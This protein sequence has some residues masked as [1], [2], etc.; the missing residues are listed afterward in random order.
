MCLIMLAIDVV[1]SLYIYRVS[2]CSILYK[3][4]YRISSVYIYPPGGLS[5]F[6]LNVTVT[7][8]IM[9]ALDVVNSLYI[10]RVS[11]CSP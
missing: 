5:I 2:A 3:G 8:L 11:A 1:N 9:L 10:Y 7:Y 6:P 4:S